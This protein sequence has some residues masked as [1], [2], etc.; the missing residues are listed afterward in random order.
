ML[1]LKVEEVNQFHRGYRLGYA[2]GLH[3]YLAAWRSS[4]DTDWKVSHI[5]ADGKEDAIRLAI[6]CID[7]NYGTEAVEAFL[8]RDLTMQELIDHGR[9]KKS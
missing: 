9:E 2:I 4:L 8:G 1:N 3:G 6:E 5:Y 7:Y